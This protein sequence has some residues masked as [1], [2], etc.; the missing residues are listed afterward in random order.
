[1]TTP[2]EGPGR[3]DPYAPPPVGADPSYRGGGQPGPPPYGEPAPYGTPAYGAPAYGAPAYGQPRPPGRNGMGTAAL[4]L[5]IVALVL[6]IV[7]IG[8]LPG[9]LA[10]IFGAIGR[11]RARR[12]EATNGGA[13][14][15]G[16]ITGI[17]AIIIAV[18][19]VSLGLSLVR[20]ELN[21]YRDCMDG[22]QTLEQRT[23]CQDD[24]RRSLEDRFSR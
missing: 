23:A 19:L 13:A 6:S 18:A 21:R 16:I 17:V 7:V 5:G 12:G 14:L 3:D 10:V 22:A 2:P 8:V 20:T 11:A 1:M 9:V 24:F 4:V 15:A